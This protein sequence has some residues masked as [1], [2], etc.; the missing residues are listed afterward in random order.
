[1][2]LNIGLHT[3][4]GD[5]ITVAAALRATSRAGIPLTGWRVADSATEPTLVAR[6]PLDSI[7]AVSKLYELAVALEQDCI[8]ARWDNGGLLIGPNTADWGEFD[9][10]YFLEF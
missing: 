7:K 6:S 9:P 5:T 2:Q 3:I 8:A 1:M 10:Q 4:N